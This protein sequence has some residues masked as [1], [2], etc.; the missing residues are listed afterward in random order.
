M[1][2]PKSRTQI[3]ID[4]MNA[5]D[6]RTAYAAA[7]HAGI[8]QS[9]LSRALKARAAKARGKKQCPMCRSMVGAAT[10]F[11]TEH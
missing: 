11:H 10:K 7:K 1:T 8:H 3:A 9:T 5:R 6:G 4:W 2:R